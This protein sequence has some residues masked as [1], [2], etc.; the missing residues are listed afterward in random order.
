VA[1]EGGMG[2][3]PA[4]HERGEK[5]RQ[6]AGGAGLGGGVGSRQGARV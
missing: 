1:R 4:V 2:G 6:G 3:G 5:Q